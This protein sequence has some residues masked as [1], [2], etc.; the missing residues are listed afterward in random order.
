MLTHLA[1]GLGLL[2]VNVLQ[3]QFALESRLKTLGHIY[4]KRCLV[5]QLVLLPLQADTQDT[6]VTKAL[7]PLNCLTALTSTVYSRW[8]SKSLLPQVR[9]AKEWL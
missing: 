7:N 8:A 9:R 1:A 4:I 3:L 5:L 6:K 2:D